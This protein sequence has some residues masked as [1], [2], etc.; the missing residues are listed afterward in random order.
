MNPFTFRPRNSDS[1][2]KRGSPKAPRKLLQKNPRLEDELRSELNVSATILEAPDQAL[3][4][5]RRRSV[6]EHVG[7]VEDVV[8]L[9]SQLNAHVFAELDVLEKSE[10]HVPEAGAA[11]LISLGHVSRERT[12]LAQRNPERWIKDSR[13]AVVTRC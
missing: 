7:M 11:E 5:F 3:I 6:H 9:A 2:K 4:D 13:V 10:I 1:Q 12:E 8:E